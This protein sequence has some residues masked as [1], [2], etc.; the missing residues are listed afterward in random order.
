MG[1]SSLAA[2]LMNFRIMSEHNYNKRNTP[3]QKNGLFSEKM[4]ENTGFWDEIRIV[5]DEIGT[6]FN[7]ESIPSSP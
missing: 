5:W 4:V 2:E 6:R 3:D 1:I 7:C